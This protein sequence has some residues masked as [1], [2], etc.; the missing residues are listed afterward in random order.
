MFLKRYSQKLLR[1]N[2]FMH[3]NIFFMLKVISMIKVKDIQLGALM[4]SG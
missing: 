1:K 2:V 3:K 4:L